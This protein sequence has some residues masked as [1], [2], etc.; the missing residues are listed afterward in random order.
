M[1]YLL[2]AAL[3]FAVLIV[4]ST[5]AGA[6]GDEAQIVG[7]VYEPYVLLQD[8]RAEGIVPDIVRETARRVGH[9]SEANFTL[10]ILRAFEMAKT[11]PG[12]FVYM[13][14]TPDHL[15]D[16]TMVF[17][18]LRDEMGGVW[19]RSR[20]WKSLDDIP[21]TAVVGFILGSPAPEP[22]TA[23]GFA[24]FSATRLSSQNAEKLIAGRIDVWMAYFSA[25]RFFLLQRG[26][27]LRDFFFSPPLVRTDVCLATGKSTPEPLVQ[28]WRDAFKSMVADGTYAAIRQKYRAY[29]PL[30]INPLPDQ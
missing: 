20:A 3:A 2:G 29:L 8:G 17:C 1:R 16:Y 22:L 15:A 5:P 19:Q 23:M 21:R 13:T 27:D 25:E 14:A 26:R 30:S 18:F 28:R 7:F 12:T 10:P 4:A 6:E 9:S 11:I 24:N